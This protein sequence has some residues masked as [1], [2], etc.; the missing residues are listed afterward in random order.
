[1]DKLSSLFF[2]DTEDDDIQLLPTVPDVAQG[3]CASSGFAYDDYTSGERGQLVS[4][5][6]GVSTSFPEEDS[7]LA[8]GMV[9]FADVDL[10]TVGRRIKPDLCSVMP[11]QARI[12]RR[13]PQI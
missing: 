7:S 6:S 2:E 13:W 11:V 9:G 10:A 3:A 1:M 8:L 4:D 5:G 12:S